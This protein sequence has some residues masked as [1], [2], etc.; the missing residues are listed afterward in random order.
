MGWQGIRSQLGYY[1]RDLSKDKKQ[2]ML[3]FIKDQGNGN[4]QL[5]V[6]LT[7]FLQ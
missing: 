6:Q 4:V 7:L 3:G 5:V 2:E 1:K